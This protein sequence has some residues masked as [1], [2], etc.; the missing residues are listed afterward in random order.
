MAIGFFDGVH[1]GHQAL[2]RH[3]K[4]VA[5][6][7][8][9]LFTVMTFSPHPDEVI[10]GEKGRKYLTPLKEKL[11]KLSAVG[12]ASISKGIGAKDVFMPKPGTV[13]KC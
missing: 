7:K 12:S 5:L 9:M 4:Q 2:L 10:Q 3:A 13:S 8:G 6:Q 1:L 11:K